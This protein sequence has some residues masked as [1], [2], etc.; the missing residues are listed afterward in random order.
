MSFRD[1]VVIIT[2]AAGEIA[3]EMSR[4]ILRKGGFVVALGLHSEPLDRFLD[5]L[6]AEGL[7]AYKRVIADISSKETMDQVIEEVI[8]EKGK[9][10]ILINHVGVALAESLHATTAEHWRT[11][12]EVN[13]NGT[14]YITDAVLKPMKAARSG[15]IITIGSVNSDRAIGNPAYSAAKAGLVS[16]MQAIATEYGQYNIRANT[17]SPGSVRT[18]A[19]DA[20]V[21]KN[22]AVFEKL[23]KWYP[24]KRIV[25]PKSVSDAVLFLASEKADYISGINLRVDAGLSAGV[26]LFA[27]DITSEDFGV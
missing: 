2:G 14:Y 7:R 9:I 24:L 18:G 5:Q 16:Y 1:K 6:D 10:D 21:E 23:L 26:A 11:E 17:V 3:Q 13:L 20:R 25:T 22:P 27:Q 8:H 15:V 19:W 12:I 4:E